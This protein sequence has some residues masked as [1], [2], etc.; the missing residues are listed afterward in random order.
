MRPFLLAIDLQEKLIPVM[1]HKEVLVKNVE[2]L[3]KAWGILKLPK[4]YTEQYPSGL[5]PT[6]PQ[7][8]AHLADA[9]YQQKTKFSAYSEHLTQ[10]LKSEHIT[11]V[12]VAGIETHVCVF[13]TVRDLLE[14]PLN[15]KLKTTSL[16]KPVNV[17]LISDALASRT[18]QNKELALSKMAGLG[19]HIATTELVLFDL[20]KDASHPHF[21]ALSRL[22][23]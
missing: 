12:F 16:Q 8:K 1:E 2:I 3:L 10:H 14:R 17:H 19:A 9:Y 6:W 13:Q 11:D 20:I 21:K 22:I 15:P 5:G 7:I 18:S 23:K 4:G